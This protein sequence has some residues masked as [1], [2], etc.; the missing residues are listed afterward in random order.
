[1]RQCN[2]KGEK[3]VE[4]L[5]SLVFFYVHST[6]RVQEAEYSVPAITFRTTDLLAER[7]KELNDGG[8]GRLPIETKSEEVCIP[9]IEATTKCYDALVT[10]AYSIYPN[11]KEAGNSANKS[12]GCS[13]NTSRGRI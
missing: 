6:K 3:F 5:L 1:M 13:R 2:S 9:E 7:E 10:E 4:P 11:N 8:Y 12:G